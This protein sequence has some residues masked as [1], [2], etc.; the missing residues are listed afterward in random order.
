MTAAPEG[1]AVSLYSGS[2]RGIPIL[3]IS[4]SAP[5]PLIEDVNTAIAADAIFDSEQRVDARFSPR[6]LARLDPKKT[7]C[8]RGQ[9]APRARNPNEAQKKIAHGLSMLLRAAADADEPDP[10]RP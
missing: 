6:C 2:S 5:P 7:G 1:A 4:G 8:I 3:L 10:A 9:S